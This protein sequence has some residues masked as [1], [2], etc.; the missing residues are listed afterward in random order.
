MT[1]RARF[2]LAALAP[3]L[4]FAGLR[5]A[6]PE[7]TAPAFL[8]L[9]YLQLPTPTGMS[10]LWETD[11]QLPG[12]V[13]FGPTAALGQAAEAKDEK[14]LH[15]VRL[16]GLRPGTTYH[17]RVRSGPLAS[18]VYSF[19]TAPPPGTRRWRLA[20][21]GDSRSR[22][23]IHRQVAAQIAKAKV[24]LIVHTGDIVL[25]GKDHDRWRKEFFEPLG[26]LARSVPWVSTIGNHERDA[27]HYFSYM[28]L[29]GNEHYFGFDFGNA[30]FVCLDSNA[31]IEKGRDSQQLNWLTDHLRQPRAATWTFVAF[32]HPLFSAHFNRSI[33]PIR[34]DW[35][36]V[37]LSPANRV[38]GVL[39][40]HDHFYAR[41]YRMG[42]LDEQPQPGVLFLTTA[43]GAAN[44]YRT[45]P[46]DYVAREKAV[47]HFTLFDFDGDRVTLSAIDITG[48]VIDRYELTKQPTPPEEFCAY[49]IEELRHYLR[50]ALRAA[51]PLAGVSE[52]ETASVDATLQVPTRFR[53][54]LRG[55][56]Q[57]E[58]VPGWEIA[59]ATSDFRLEPG[60]PLVIPLKATVA[61]GPYPHSP[62]LTI[63]F[64]PGKFHNRTIDL[65]PFKL[66]GPEAVR[67]GR[68]AK[69]PFVDGRLE[70]D[71]WQASPGLTLLGNPPHGGR[72]DRVSLLADAAWL[73]VGATLD[74]PAG[75]VKV[76][77]AES[78]PGS[79]L[80][81][82]H[83][84][85]V[86][87]DGKQSHTFAVSPEQFRQ[88]LIGG[89]EETETVWKAAAGRGDHVWH[90]E[91]AVPRQLFADWSQVRINVVHRRGGRT[92]ATEYE[93]CPTFVMGGDP[94]LIPDWKAGADVERF[95]RLRLE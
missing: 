81:S 19:K 21:Y 26:S 65:Y 66:A 15:E 48:A 42:R 52:R 50:L 41:N 85:V 92:G 3:L 93:L 4:F 25:S 86:L 2:S 95:A 63:A 70:Q 37:L 12:R 5:G 84:R 73:Y 31:W 43:G 23:E 6:P 76:A 49:E 20:V 13:E 29:P 78:R 90:A 47:H 38:D 27:D 46:R 14:A 8:V 54:A 30:H 10:V 28:A 1:R 44:L 69:T 40:G 79:V 94:D 60:Q 72:G 53:V 51:A 7:E 18:E 89:K 74:D 67:V 75:R 56:L 77:A 39:A 91:L 35:A 34:W 80:T 16:E 88:H 58:K 17:Y 61:P 45:K 82:E 55:Q 9:P 24:D 11:R 36:P 64:A 83:V 68:A 57:W 32:H 71:V 33:N 59:T 87:S 62:K 22:P